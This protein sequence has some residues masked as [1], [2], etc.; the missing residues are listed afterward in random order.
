LKHGA[1]NSWQGKEEY[2]PSTQNVV[3]IAGGNAEADANTILTKTINHKIL[4]VDADTMDMLKVMG[5]NLPGVKLQQVPPP[6]LA[7]P[8]PCAPLGL[9]QPHLQNRSI[10]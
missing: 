8:P 9:N 4:Q 7:S 10:G 2:S 3:G 1:A 6:P 5:M